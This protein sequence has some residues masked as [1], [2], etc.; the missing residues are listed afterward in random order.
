MTAI[1]SL[2][3]VL[4]VALNSTTHFG[5]DEV[6]STRVPEDVGRQQVSQCTALR[7]T[8]LAVQMW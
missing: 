3:D 4:Q 2:T 7:A 8:E 1:N 5:L 6:R